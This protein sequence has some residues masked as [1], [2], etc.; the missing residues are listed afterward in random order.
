MESTRRIDLRPLRTDEDFAACVELQQLIWG[1]DVREM[2]PPALLKVCQ[3]VGG[4]AAGAFDQTGRLVG[5]VF[6]VTGIVNEETTHWSHLLAVKPGLRD[7]SIGRSLKLYQRE[8]L[9]AVGVKTASWT[10]DPLVAR[11]AYL[12]LCLLGATIEQYVQDMY[13]AESTSKTDEVIGSDRVVVR[14]DLATT[15]AT[16]SH[17]NT[18]PMEEVPAVSLGVG[19]LPTGPRVRIEVPLD[20]QRLKDESP[21]VAA[22]W[23]AITRRAFQHYLGRR[24]CVSRF[25]RQ[26][27]PNLSYYLLQSEQTKGNN[28]PT[29]AS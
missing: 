12:N 8:Q 26:D 4:I 22:Q 29:A 14:W 16:E 28:E 24:Y 19:N 1:D 18:E 3:R 2:V 11:N 21:D 15:E 13:G 9:L 6:G 5:F 25:V 27:A 7:Q 20:I 23:R 10:Y 17:G